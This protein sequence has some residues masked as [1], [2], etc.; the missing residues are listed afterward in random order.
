MT[1]KATDPRSLA[2]AGRTPPTAVADEFALLTRELMK[3]GF[4]STY[5]AVRECANSVHE[6]FCELNES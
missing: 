6:E 4:V 3:A 1:E 2:T 5:P